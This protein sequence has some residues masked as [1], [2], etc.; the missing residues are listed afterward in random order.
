MAIFIESG[1][2][3]E[4]PDDQLFFIEQSNF[5]KL[6]VG[7]ATVEF[8]YFQKNNLLW[9]EAKSSF[10]RAENKEHFEENITAIADKFIHSFELYLSHFLSV[11][12][13]IPSETPEMFLNYDFSKK[14]PLKF[15]LIINCGKIKKSNIPQ[16][17]STIQNTFLKRFN[18]HRSIWNVQFIALDHESAIEYKLVKELAV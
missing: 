12:K 3:F 8:L 17:I 4:L 9:V 2:R 1:M 5:F 6:K 13:L 15:V 10:P 7:V 14:M 16:M 18:G 11:N